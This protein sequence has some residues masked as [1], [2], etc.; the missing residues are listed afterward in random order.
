MVG[1]AVGVVVLLACQFS[2]TAAS[3]LAAL[4]AGVTAAVVHVGI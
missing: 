2:H 3:L 1:L 4:V